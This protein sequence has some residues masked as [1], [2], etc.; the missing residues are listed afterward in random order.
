MCH[1]DYNFSVYLATNMYLEY[2]EFNKV[3]IIT[4]CKIKYAYINKNTLKL[5][6]NF[7]MLG[8]WVEIMWLSLLLR[9]NCRNKVFEKLF[10]VI[11]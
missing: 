8:L 7:P 9:W 3:K 1:S 10:A 4:F 5:F 2:W 6:N 11:E